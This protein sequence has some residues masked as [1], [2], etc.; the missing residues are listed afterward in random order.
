VTDGTE[1]ICRPADTRL[2]ALRRSGQH[3]GVEPHA[4]HH[5]EELPVAGTN[6]DPATATLQRHLDPGGQVR[7]Q[8]EVRGDQVAGAGRQDRQCHVRADQRGHRRHDGPVAA[9]HEDQLRTGFD[10]LAC[11]PAP[12]ILRCGLEPLGSGPP[13]PGKRAVDRLSKLVDLV[14]L[15]RVDD[16]G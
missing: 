12:W 6:V 14:D 16:D 4:G 2:G 10:G 8:S 1:H 9:A 13:C 3:V 7:G 11:L 15:G 5:D